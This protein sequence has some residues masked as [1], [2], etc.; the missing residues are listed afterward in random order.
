MGTRLAILHFCKTGRGAAQHARSGSTRLQRL[1]RGAGGT[2]QI[3]PG[4][5]LC[6][7]GPS[8]SRGT[9]MSTSRR[10]SVKITGQ[11]L[12]LTEDAELL[13]Q[14]LAGEAIAFEPERHALVDNI[15]TDE[16]TPGL[17]LL[18]LRRDARAVLPG[19]PA[20]RRDPAGRD[21]G[22]RLRGHRQRPLEGLRQLARDGAVLASSRPACKLV[23]AKSIEKIYGQ[24]C[25]NIG[26]LTT[27]DFGDPRAHRARR[28]DPDQ[29]VHARASTRSAPTSSSTAGSSR[30]T[31][32]AWR[33]RSSPPTIDDAPRGR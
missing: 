29:R 2:K 16:I 17:G 9:P 11:V 15:S 10:K 27:T 24:N 23:V 14:Q 13:K 21:Q 28:G 5:P 6:P 26:L 3:G 20:R 18:L 19:R 1:A 30:T 8:T 12:Y 31:R 7:D 32:R 4:Q 33:A 25:Q 22:R